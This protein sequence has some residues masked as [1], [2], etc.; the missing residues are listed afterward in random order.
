MDFPSVT[1]VLSMF[2]N[3]GAIPDDVVEAA[4]ARGTKTHRACFSYQQGLYVAD[5]GE[6]QGYFQSFKLWFDEFVDADWIL[7]AEHRLVDQVTGFTGTP[8]LVPILKSGELAVIDY[9]TSATV[10]PT[11]RPQLAAYKWLVEQETG[12]KV[13]ATIAL[14]LS[15]GGRMAKAIRTEG[16]WNYDWPVFVSA[17]NCYRYF[18]AKDA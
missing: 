2:A 10:Q 14:Q 5:L 7:F 6:H 9:K 8:D 17:L 11:W 16:S 4:K 1:Q 3:F 12:E 15:R 18:G 13:Y